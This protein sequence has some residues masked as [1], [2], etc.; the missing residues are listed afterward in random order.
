[1]K[2]KIEKKETK[3]HEMKEVKMACGTKMPKKKK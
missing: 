3:K 2:K 1:M